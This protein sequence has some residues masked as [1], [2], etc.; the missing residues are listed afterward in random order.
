MVEGLQHETLA[1]PLALT[2]AALHQQGVAQE[3]GL[4]DQ[5]VP[6]LVVP[7]LGRKEED[8]EGGREEQELL[9]AA[10]G[11]AQERGGAQHVGLAVVVVRSVEVHL[12]GVDKDHV[13]VEAEGAVDVRSDA[14]PVF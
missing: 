5:R 14:Q 7:R 10:E 12:G 9:L 13:D 2:V 11:Q 6:R 3:V 1:G 8:A 4:A